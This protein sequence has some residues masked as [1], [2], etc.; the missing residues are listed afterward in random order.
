MRL[1][2]RLPNVPGMKKSYWFAL[3]GSSL[4]LLA[5]LIGFKVHQAGKAP[6]PMAHTLEYNNVVDEHI[7]TVKVPR[8]EID[9]AV[10]KQ[11][12]GQRFAIY[13]FSHPKLRGNWGDLNV[14]V[15]RQTGKSVS[16]SLFPVGKARP[17]FTLSSLPEC[18]MA[19]QPK[20]SYEICVR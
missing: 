18:L 10:A 16:R 20:Q 5:G 6:Q 14:L 13:Q 12:V 7:D 4:V 19:E 11:E 8:A 3:G 9:L 15:D 2:M 1:T 17:N